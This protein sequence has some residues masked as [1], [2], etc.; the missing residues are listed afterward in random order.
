M[1]K[2]ISWHRSYYKKQIKILRL[3]KSANLKNECNSTLD[4][5]IV[6]IV[7][8]KIRGR[9][10]EKKHRK[11]NNRKYKKGDKKHGEKA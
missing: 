10:I 7:K 11:A 9:C 3:Q 2:C 5:H 8:Q 6:E 4:Q 1:T